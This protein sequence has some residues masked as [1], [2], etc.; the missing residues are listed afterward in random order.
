MKPRL[1]PH[2]KKVRGL[3]RLNYK[4]GHKKRPLDCSKGLN[5]GGDPDEAEQALLS[6]A[7][8]RTSTIGAAG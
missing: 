6:H 2:S 3:S 7:P 4:R 8:W 1:G 5:E